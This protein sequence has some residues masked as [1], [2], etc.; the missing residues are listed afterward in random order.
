MEIIRI[1][2]SYYSQLEYLPDKD[3][4]YVLK[5]VFE[6]CNLRDVKVEKS[7]RW[8]VVISIYRE[9]LQMEN[10]AR[11]KKWKKRLELDIATL[12]GDTEEEH[13]VRPSNIKESNITEHKI[14]EKK[15][16][17]I[18]VTK[19][20]TLKDYMYSNIDKEYFITNY[21]STD[22]FINK[23]MNSFYY[24]RAEKK[25]NWKK[26]RWEMEKT[27]DVNLR[28]HNRLKNTSKFNV[29]LS[30]D[31]ERKIKLAEIE[32]KKKVLFNKF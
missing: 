20:T 1:P 14:K 5:T 21:N 16:I 28:F 11:A 30:E 8:G 17:S 9:A 31:E 29:T 12:M 10:K 15:E 24:Y 4:N 7:M 23:E 26:E 13:I 32:K 22:E 25:P 3:F 19:V 2:S 6:L 18:V 27:F